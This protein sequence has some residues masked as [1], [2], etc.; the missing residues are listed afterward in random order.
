MI[1][2]I[3]LVFCFEFCDFIKFIIINL[4]GDLIL[5]WSCLFLQERANAL[6]LVMAQPLDE[7]VPPFVLQMYG[8]TNSFDTQD[9]IR[10]WDITKSMLEKYDQMNF[11]VN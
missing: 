6:Y 3:L 2:F 10:R 11:Y 4:K 7:K 8:T 9:V 1:N 5:S